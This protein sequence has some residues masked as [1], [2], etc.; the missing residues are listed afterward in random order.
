[1]YLQ[2]TAS[3]TNRKTHRVPRKYPYYQHGTAKRHNQSQPNLLIYATDAG[4]QPTSE[5]T[6]I[7]RCEAQT[8]SVSMRQ[9]LQPTSNTKTKSKRVK[10][11]IGFSANQSWA[12]TPRFLASARFIGTHTVTTEL[13]TDAHVEKEKQESKSL[14]PQTTQAPVRAGYTLRSQTKLQKPSKLHGVHCLNLKRTHSTFLPFGALLGGW[15]LSPSAY[16]PP[17]ADCLLTCKHSKQGKRRQQCST[18]CHCS[19]L[20]TR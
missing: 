7:A 11:G 8:T 14:Q 2:A 5:H 6:S 4:K 15:V 9:G 16:P 18:I 13:A 19:D 20:A 12:N 1:M 17:L 10:C 3:K